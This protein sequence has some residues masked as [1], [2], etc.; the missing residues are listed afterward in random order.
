MINDCISESP[1]GWVSSIILGSN[2]RDAARYINAYQVKQIS[3]LL[4][5]NQDFTKLNYLIEALG[6]YV[7]LEL[8]KG[9][10]ET[11][12]PFPFDYRAGHA[13]ILQFIE[14]KNENF[15]DLLQLNSIHCQDIEIECINQPE[16]VLL[17]QVEPI[18]YALIL[19]KIHLKS[20]QPKDT[21]TLINL[22]ILKNFTSASNT[23]QISFKKSND[24]AVLTGLYKQHHTTC[25]EL[26]FT[27]LDY[28]QRCL[29]V[30]EKIKSSQPQANYT[31]LSSDP[32]TEDENSPPTKKMKS[33]KQVPCSDDTP[34]NTS[35]PMVQRMPYSEMSAVSTDINLSD[36]REASLQ[37]VQ[38]AKISCTPSKSTDEN[39]IKITPQNTPKKGN[40]QRR[41]RLSISNPLNN[42]APPELLPSRDVQEFAINQLQKNK[43]YSKHSM[44]RFQQTGKDVWEIP[45]TPT[46]RRSK[47]KVKN[48]SKNE[49]NNETDEKIK[50]PKI[51]F[52][53]NN[54]QDVDTSKNEQTDTCE[55]NK[56]M[57]IV[58]P[59]ATIDT[60]LRHQQES[61]VDSRSEF[62]L[63]YESYSMG[64]GQMLN[65]Q[66]N[67]P[68]NGIM[69]EQD[70]WGSL[71]SVYETLQ[72]FSQSII[73]DI[74]KR[75]FMLKEV[76]EEFANETSQLEQEFENQKNLI[77]N[78]SKKIFAETKLK[79]D[80]ISNRLKA[81]IDKINSQFV[82]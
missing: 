32:Y 14:A 25:M 26:K 29:T 41:P 71:D 61:F 28:T 11:I 79:S 20:D 19:W 8:V 3:K 57:D 59:S 10:P 39:T 45:L 5:Q 75:E 36:R 47:D 38:P 66:Q 18:G 16:I 60:S 37:Y 48:I 55:A 54:L 24:F 58:S 33:V 7:P 77:I 22:N 13:K 56:I 23:V 76:Y 72:V 80:D 42:A 34:I 40:M 69:I 74:K 30:L 21:V 2:A 82:L 1:T 65:R 6:S 51:G 67:R 53:P 15:T 49:I 73:R 78:E 17:L 9:I 12:Y 43:K 62:P 81:K 50:V 70:I 68:Q 64:K 4:E 44:R 46:Q 31:L 27:R 63:F 35:T 52:A